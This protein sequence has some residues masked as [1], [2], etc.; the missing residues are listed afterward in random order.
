MHKIKDT[1][2]RGKDRAGKWQYGD[3]IHET[4]TRRLFILPEI[5]QIETGL[6]R[7]PNASEILP[8]TLGRSTGIEDI[9]KKLL[10]E[11]DLVENKAREISKIF[12]QDGSPNDLVILCGVPVAYILTPQRV[13]EMR[14]ESI[15]NVFDNPDL[16][17]DDFTL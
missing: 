10:F 11:G 9:N 6:F 14:L 5:E 12:I 3:L 1:I 8:P 2:C 16:W 7:A 15:G 17:K 13:R 4:K